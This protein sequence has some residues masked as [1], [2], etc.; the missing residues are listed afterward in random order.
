MAEQRTLQE[1]VAWWV[2]A[3]GS[4][5]TWATASAPQSGLFGLVTNMTY[6]SAADFKAVTERG[7]P[8]H[9]KIGEKKP[10][11]ITIEFGYTGYI[12]TALSGS[13]AS[14]PMW[15]LEYKATQPEVGNTGR[16]FQF[17]GVPLGSIDFKEATDG[18]TISLKLQALAMNGPTGSGYLS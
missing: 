18:D 1:G 10:I 13:G 17:H 16:Y 5:R 8:D 7:V 9:W 15:H 6:T 4:G 2:A 14:V 3:S 12:P 11:D